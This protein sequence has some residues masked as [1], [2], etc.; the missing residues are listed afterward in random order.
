MV[1]HRDHDHSRLRRHGAEDLSR[2]VRRL[3]VRADR[4]ADHS[5]SGSGDRIQLRA[6]LLSHP[7]AGQA[8]QEA[9]ARAAG[10]GG[11]T[12]GWTRW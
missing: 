2:N 7:G 8:A 10:R 1:G 9:T 3:A 12:E 4:R 11:A 5:T 6:V